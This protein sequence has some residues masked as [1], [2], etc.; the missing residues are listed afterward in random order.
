MGKRALITLNEEMVTI[1]KINKFL[2][3]SGILLK[4]V[5]KNIENKIKEWKCGFLGFLVASLLGNMIAGKG[6]I[7]T[8]QRVSTNWW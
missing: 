3:E 2:R 8:A 6:V 4:Y 1:M 5:G 7:T